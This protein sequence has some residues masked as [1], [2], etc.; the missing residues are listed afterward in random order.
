[1]V[2]STSFRL[3][4]AEHR[5]RKRKYVPCFR[6]YGDPR[7]LFNNIDAI[8]L[9]KSLDEFKNEITRIVPLYGGRC[10]D[11]TP[12]TGEAAL[13]LAERVLDASHFDFCL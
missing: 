13:T 8:L 1:M 2:Y 6:C 9:A 11:V 10:F 3:F 4:S 12:N 7:N 5:R